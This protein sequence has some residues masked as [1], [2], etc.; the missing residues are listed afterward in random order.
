MMRVAAARRHSNLLYSGD[1]KPL[2]VSKP[3]D[4][5]LD[6]EW[7]RSNPQSETYGSERHAAAMRLYLEIAKA[8]KINL[9]ELTFP[10]RFDFDDGE[11]RP[12][13]GVMKVYLDKGLVVG[14][15]MGAQLVFDVTR[16]GE[17]YLMERA[18]RL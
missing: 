2:S 7:W 11:M 18:T 4:R 14:R 17:R 1:S 13:K 5:P 16:D 8:S 3:E 15:L 6:L 10:A 12:D 9:P